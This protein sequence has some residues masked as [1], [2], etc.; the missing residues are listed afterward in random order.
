MTGIAISKPTHDL[1]TRRQRIARVVAEWVRRLF[2]FRPTS[3]S[4]CPSASE[5]AGITR[6]DRFDIVPWLSL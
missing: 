2:A 3:R 5:L 4:A 6:V 1:Q